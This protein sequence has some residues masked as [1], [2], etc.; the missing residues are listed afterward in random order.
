MCRVRTLFGSAGVSVRVRTRCRLD[1]LRE[2]SGDTRGRGARQQQ[3][4]VQPLKLWRGEP[5]KK[6]IDQ[7]GDCAVQIAHRRVS[8][9]GEF[10]HHQPA[11]G[12]PALPLNPAGTLHPINDARYVWYLRD[13]ARANLILAEP[14]IPGFTKDAKDVQLRWGEP[15]GPQTDLEFVPGGCRCPRQIQPEFFTEAG[16]RS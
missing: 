9:L 3:Q 16:C 5:R 4:L 6:T 11:I 12:E 7:Q 8:A 15:K 14:G 13:Q 1:V 2:I 10:R